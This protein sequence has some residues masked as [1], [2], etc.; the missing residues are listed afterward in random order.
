MSKAVDRMPHLRGAADTTGTYRRERNRIKEDCVLVEVYS[1][2][3]KRTHSKPFFELEPAP[4]FMII[5]K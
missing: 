4:L 3:E 5:I 2:Q 1:Q